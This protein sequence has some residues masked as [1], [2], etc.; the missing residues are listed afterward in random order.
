MPV[1]SLLW[2]NETQI[3]AAGYDCAPLLYETKNG[4]EW[5]FSGS[6]DVGQ[7]KTSQTSS[8]LARFK[9]MDT[10]GETENDTTLNTVHQNSIK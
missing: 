10:R 3:I 2:A 5:Q 1:R 6:L 8:V 7:K 4:Q 9:T